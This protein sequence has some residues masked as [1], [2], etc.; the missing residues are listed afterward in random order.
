[1]LTRKLA[2]VGALA[3]VGVFGWPCAGPL[4]A[5]NR[6]V[7]GEFE[8]DPPGTQVPTGWT[9]DTNDPVG[10]VGVL[11]YGSIGGGHPVARPDGQGQPNCYGDVLYSYANSWGKISQTIALDYA[12]VPTE[13]R[14]G[15][16]VYT[17][18]TPGAYVAFEVDQ[19]ATGAD[20]E[21]GA[22]YALCGGNPCWTWH[23]F[24]I[25]TDEG[26]DG[27]DI[28]FSVEIQTGYGPGGLSPHGMFVDGLEVERRAGPGGA[29]C[30]DDGGCIEVQ[31]EEECLNQQPPG[32]WAG[33]DTDCSTDDNDNGVADA[34]EACVLHDPF[35]D[36]DGDGDV[37]Q[38]DFGVIQ[39][40]L[41]GSGDPDGV[42]DPVLCSCYDWN[43]DEDVDQWDLAAFEGCASGPE[44]PADPSCDD[45]YQ[46]TITEWRSMKFHGGEING[47]LPIVLD[48][49]S[50][51]GTAETRRDGIEII[52]VDF[53]GDISSALQ[54]STVD[55]TELNGST[56]YTGNCTPADDDTLRIIFD[57]PLPDEGCYEIDLAGVIDGLIGD[58]DCR[59]RGLQGDIN[60]DSSTNLIDMA[61][62]KAMNGADPVEPGNARLDVN[63]D[64]AINLIDMA[65]VKALNGGSVSCPL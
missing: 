64:G 24:T 39:V 33:M 2:W 42:F 37:D 48:A 63:T 7:N 29:C 49:A 10:W 47:E 19:P 11:E 15:G 40:C 34:C 30:L 62:V 36:A 18:D 26:F 1:M 50:D 12:G 31:S 41:T 55:A 4:M 27:S 59:V 56:P 32:T 60:G 53:Y 16:W 22:I 25:T 3:L 13:F 14:I 35:A 21:S 46:V 23:E 54:T 51:T 5:D 57:P 6:V 28:E 44:V 38:E 52:E 45:L 8:A 9:L 20:W 17:A 65:A 43:G 61:A 58:T